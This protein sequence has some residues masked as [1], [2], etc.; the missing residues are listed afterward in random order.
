MFCKAKNDGNQHSSSEGP[1]VANINFD[2]VNETEFYNE[3]FAILNEE[4]VDSQISPLRR[5]S[6]LTRI[7]IMSFLQKWRK[8]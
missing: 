3:P 7:L 4:T 6:D 2:D 5:S 1:S 8:S